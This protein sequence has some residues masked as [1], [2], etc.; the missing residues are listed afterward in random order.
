[1]DFPGI[2]QMGDPAGQYPG[3]ARARTGNH[4]Y[5]CTGMQYGGALGRVESLKQGGGF[6]HGGSTL[7]KMMS[8]SGLPARYPDR[9]P[10]SSTAGWA[11]RPV[12]LA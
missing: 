8:P 10:E 2:D 3:L 1:M 11:G 9:S 12:R 4:Q 7:P 6:S 5:R